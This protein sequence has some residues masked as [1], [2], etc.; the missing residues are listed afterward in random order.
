M[1]DLLDK[2]NVSK[3]ITYNIAPQKKF[4]QKHMIKTFEVEYSINE[5]SL[6][7]ERELDGIFVYTTN[8]IEKENNHYKMPAYDIIKHYKDKYVIEQAFRHIKSTLD[9]RPMY[10]WLPEH[11]NA[12]IDICM[13]SYFINNFIE[14]RL[15][16][17]SSLSNFYSLLENHSKSCLIDTG[18][19][20]TVSLIKKPSPDL[21]KAIK[22]LNCNVVVSQKVLEGYGI[23]C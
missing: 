23:Q 19:G 17:Y 8:H 13:T 11:V 4:G 14:T 15:K 18:R 12:H 22:A 7:S 10:V 21:A 6:Q 2:K 9:L 3:I 5:Q 1:I 16:E 20:E